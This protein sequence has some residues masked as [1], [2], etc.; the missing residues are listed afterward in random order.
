MST[1]DVERFLEMMDSDLEFRTA[2]EKAE[3]WDE[4]WKVVTAANLQFSDA[5][6][7]DL[8]ARRAATGA[9]AGDEETPKPGS[10]W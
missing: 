1:V 6:L 3:S 10:H 9:E 4:A 7:V 2:F 5:E 8:L